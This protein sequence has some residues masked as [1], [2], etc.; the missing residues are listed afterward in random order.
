VASMGVLYY[1]HKLKQ[2]TKAQGKSEHEVKTCDPEGASLW[3]ILAPPRWTTRIAAAS[4]IPPAFYLSGRILNEG[5]RGTFWYIMSLTPLML[6]WIEI[7]R[8]G[9]YKIGSILSAIGLCLTTTNCLK[10]AGGDVGSFVLCGALSSIAPA[11]C[12]YE[13]FSNSSA[14]VQELISSYSWDNFEAQWDELDKDKEG[15]CEEDVQKLAADFVTNIGDTFVKG[16]KLSGRETITKVWAHLRPLLK[17]N[18]STLVSVILDQKRSSIEI[19]GRMV[20]PKL[21]K[22]QILDI[23]TQTMQDLPME[24]LP[25]VAKA[26]SFQGSVEIVRML[27]NIGN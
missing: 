8:I 4:L 10:V 22:N 26:T 21:K 5:F 23:F 25:L 17:E 24:I 19:E 18:I 1:N 14:R 15:L 2:A 12:L 3:D 27:D 7:R 20:K 16:W 13:N 6:N 9:G 11:Y